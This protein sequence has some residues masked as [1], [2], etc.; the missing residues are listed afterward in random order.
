MIAKRLLFALFIALVALPLVGCGAKADEY[1]PNK[2]AVKQPGNGPP[3]MGHP[4]TPG[5]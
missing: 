2:I 4:G 3:P 5:K 1:D